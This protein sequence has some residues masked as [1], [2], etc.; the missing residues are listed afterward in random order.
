MKTNFLAAAALALVMT[1]GAALAQ[2]AAPMHRH[3]GAFGGPM[4]GLF[5][6]QLGLSD[7]QKAQMKDIMTKEKPTMK[8][9]MQQL[10]QSQAQLRQ[11]EL[12]N[13]DEAQARTIATQQAQTMTELSVQ[14]ARVEAELIQVLTP[15]QKTKLNQLWQQRQQRFMN[16][17]AE[18]PQAQ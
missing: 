6:H 1:G 13:F 10:G 2:D 17:N 15:D 14:R 8:P 18:A 3:G 5:G 7:A 12:N 16:H 9:L 11:L 4:F